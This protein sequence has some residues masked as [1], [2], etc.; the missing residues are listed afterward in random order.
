MKNK[1]SLVVGMG[2]GQLYKSVLT[3]MGHEVVT[4]DPDISKGAD[5]PNVKSAIIAHGMFDTAHICTPNFTHKEIAEQISPYTKMIFIE[6]PGLQSSKDWTDL[7]KKR[8]FNR[9]MMVKNNMW[10]DNLDEMRALI[11]DAKAVK[12]RWINKNRIPSP[13]SWFTTKELAFGG[14]S[15]DLMPHLLSLY[16][17]INEDWL[18]ATLTGD[19]A[20]QKHTLENIESTEYGTVNKDGIYDVDD[21]CKIKYAYH[22]RTW[23][24]EANWADGI[25]DNRAIEFEMKDGT[26][27]R[28]ELGLCPESAYKAMLE[29]AVANF[30]N[31]NWWQNQYVQDLWIHERIEKF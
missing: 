29:E 19:E 8:P 6:K 22:G 9:F 16:I 2:I 3:E 28:F 26:V 13:G 10:R 21:L 7:V 15:R 30:E 12:F 17:A 4:V 5:L 18:N 31:N 1:I 20:R 14:V 24:L 27:K 25:E 11:P 23:K